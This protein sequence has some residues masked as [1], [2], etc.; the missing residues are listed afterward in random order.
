MGF[1]DE[2]LAHGTGFIYE[3]NG[4]FYLITNWHVVTGKH[5]ETEEYLS[6]HA[7][8]PN[9]VCTYFREKENPGNGHKE[10]INLYS[11]GDMQ[12]PIW[13]EHPAHK[14]KVDVVAIPIPKSIA[15]KYELHPINNIGFDSSFKEEVADETFVIGFPFDEPTYLG[16]PIWKKASISSE[17]DVNINQL[18]M[19][20]IDT[21]TRPGL[22]GSPV[23]M[24]RI[25]IH[26]V[27]GGKVSNDTLIGRIRN[28]IGIYSGRIGEDEFKAQLGVVWKAKVIE[29][30]LAE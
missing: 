8:I 30:I 15:S 14:N 2:V 5:P 16:L 3:K 24:Q 17:P 11:D 18:P 21:A 20:Y 4:Q 6:D 25:G 27:V 19:L 23:I 9:V 10:I 7:G 22:S 12:M 1:N 13:K 26:G 29:E 28:F